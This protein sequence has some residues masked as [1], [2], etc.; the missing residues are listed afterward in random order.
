M[1]ATSG[2][3]NRNSVSL[4][5]VHNFAKLRLEVNL[6]LAITEQQYKHPSN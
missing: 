3:L 2:G 6:E 1:T 5:L 4:G